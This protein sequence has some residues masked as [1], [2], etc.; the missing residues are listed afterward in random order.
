MKTIKQNVLKG[1]TMMLIISM[2]ISI[3]TACGPVSPQAETTSESQV[4][5]TSNTTEDDEDVYSIPWAKIDMSVHD[6]KLL[7]A[8]VRDVA[9]DQDIETKTLI[10]RVMIYRILDDE[11]A[12]SISELVPEYTD[13]PN[14]TTE[15]ACFNAISANP[16]G[17][18]RDMLWFQRD[19]Y[20]EDHYD[21]LNSGDFYFSTRND[22]SEN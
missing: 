11:F 3:A 1:I 19:S 14:D 15:L 18:P 22:Y 12:N 7:C 5:T 16:F 4:E 21:Y 6:F 9:D 20:N 17:E 13:F 2:L 8:Y 10:A